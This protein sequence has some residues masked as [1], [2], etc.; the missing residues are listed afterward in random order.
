[1]YKNVNIQNY[2]RTEF[3]MRCFGESLH[4]CINTVYWR[5]FESL[6]KKIYLNEAIWQSADL[7]QCLWTRDVQVEFLQIIYIH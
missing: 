2:I 1:M 7:L 4:S 3:L 6:I 5:F